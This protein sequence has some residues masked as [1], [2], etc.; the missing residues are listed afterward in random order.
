MS[1][2]RQLA[3]ADSFAELFTDHGERAFRY[4][5][6]IGLSTEDADDVVAESFARVW[7]ARDSF[8]GEAQPSTWLLR[9]VRNQA[10]NWLRGEK[11][12]CLRHEASASRPAR[13]RGSDPA[14][15][16]EAA[17]MNRFLARAVDDLPVD[18]RSALSLVTAGEMSYREAA[19]LEEVTAATIGRRVFLARKAVRRALASKGLL[20]V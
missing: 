12:R 10:L 15:S 16:T 11:R 19:Q 17:E 13:P 5:R 7:A 3:D 9:V 1:R 8:R 20:E 18:L 6:M 2:Q 14:E 4:A